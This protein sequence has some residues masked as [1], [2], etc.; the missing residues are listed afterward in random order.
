MPRYISRRS[1]TLKQPFSIKKFY[2]QRNKV[3][4]V[5]ETGGLG[6]LLMHRMMFEDMK[7]LWPDCE[8]IFACQTKYHDAVSDHPFLDAVIDMNHANPL[9]YVVAYNTTSACTRHEMMVAPFSDKHRSD[10][11]ANHCGVILKNHNMHFRLDGRFKDMA[12]AKIKKLKGDHPGP[13]VALCPYS[14]M[15]VKNLLPHQMQELVRGL[16]DMGAFVVCLHYVPV[17]ELA[18]LG[19]P[20]LA[21]L[22]TKEWMGVLDAVDYVVTVDTAAFHFAGGR[23]KPMT[24]IFTCFDGKVYGKYYNFELVQK[25]RDNGD[26][27]CGPCYVFNTCP[28]CPTNPK[29]CLTELTSAMML[30]AVERMLAKSLRTGSSQKFPLLPT[31]QSTP[32][33]PP[34]PHTST[35]PS[36]CGFG[37]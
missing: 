25:H 30:D 15:K 14:A 28:K 22:S 24:A 34:G 2:E 7:K 36:A 1:S 21:G 3:L 10:I 9:D 16:H 23:G 5:R 32:Q 29:P 19:V 27:D 8:L 37:Q 6:D 4:I 18:P 17:V 35:E 33:C 12:L 20:T 11:W 31:H 26:W 13:V